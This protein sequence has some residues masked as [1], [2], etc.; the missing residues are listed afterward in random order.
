MKMMKTLLKNS[1]HLIVLTALNLVYTFAGAILFIELEECLPRG[2]T[3]GQEEV[4]FMKYLK[5]IEN[6]TTE[7]HESIINVST[8]FFRHA[9]RRTCSFGE[10]MIVKWWEFTIVS[11]STIGEYG[12]HLVTIFLL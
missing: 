1:T 9:S 5:G 8:S 11:S 4:D 12:D 2:V 7:E 10:K 6:M 3:I